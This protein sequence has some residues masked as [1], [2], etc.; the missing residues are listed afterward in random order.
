MEHQRALQRQAE[1]RKALEQYGQ[2][3]DISALK[4]VAPETALKMQAA[5]M[6]IAAGR[7]EAAGRFFDL[8]APFLDTKEG[9]LK[10]YKDVETKYD[11][12]TQGWPIPKTDEEAKAIVDRMLRLRGKQKAEHAVLMEDP[13]TGQYRIFSTGTT[14]PH[15]VKAPTGRMTE[16]YR[17]LTALGRPITEEEI[18][19]A[20]KELGFTKEEVLH[21]VKLFQNPDDPNDIRYFEVGKEP[22]GW[23]PYEKE[24]LTEE[25]LEKWKVEQ[26]LKSIEFNDT[27]REEFN[28][29]TPERKVEILREQM[30]AIGEVA[31][32]PKRQLKSTAKANREKIRQAIARK[33]EEI[34]ALPEGPQKEEQKRQLKE[35]ERKY[36]GTE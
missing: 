16:I 18:A 23:V 6:E 32:K 11:I 8:Q 31:P 1:A 22:K 29:A 35:A 24:K 36:L 27:L 19:K 30:K 26:A 2:T 25:Q 20:A 13:R 5:Q 7:I 12:S 28:R 34:N 15:V 21:N 4:K 17:Y 14:T 3:G 9:L 33:Q 10:F